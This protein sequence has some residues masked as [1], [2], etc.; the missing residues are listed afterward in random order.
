MKRL[1]QTEQPEE[2]FTLQ[3]TVLLNSSCTLQFCIMYDIG[4]FSIADICSSSPKVSLKGSRPPAHVLQ[5]MRDWQKRQHCNLFT[6]PSSECWLS[7]DFGALGFKIPGRIAHIKQ[8]MEEQR[9]SMFCT[10]EDKMILSLTLYWE[11]WA[12]S[13]AK[14]IFSSPQGALKSA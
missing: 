8:L 7:S 14:K 11:L 4:K 5:C 12:R 1:T 2:S 13:L 6:A 3:D 10:S 9:A